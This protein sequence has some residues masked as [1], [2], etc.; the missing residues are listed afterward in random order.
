MAGL[1][2]RAQE[3]V[4]RGQVSESELGGLVLHRSAETGLTRTARQGA[5]AALASVARAQ[6]T[7]AQRSAASGSADSTAEEAR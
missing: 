4:K 3:R 5:G 7:E 1:S 2:Q 6:A